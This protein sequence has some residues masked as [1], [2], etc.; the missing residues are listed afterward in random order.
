MYDR[1]TYELG[2]SDG[3]VNEPDYP[4][5]TGVDG[6]LQKGF[7]VGGGTTVSPITF[8]I[9]LIA[10]LVGMKLLGESSKTDIQPAH[11]AIG[12]YNVVAVTVTAIVGIVLSKAIFNS[13][14]LAGL[15]GLDSVQAVVNAA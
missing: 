4:A 11:F 8:L 14:L 6:P 9:A 13:S 7:P 10:L 1:D 15:P 5:P 12:G 2:L 3:Y